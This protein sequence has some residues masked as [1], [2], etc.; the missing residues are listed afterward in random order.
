MNEIENKV[1]EYDVKR[2]ELYWKIQK[3][4]EE[5]PSEELTKIEEKYEEGIFPE[6]KLNMSEEKP[7]T[8]KVCRY[9]SHGFCKHGDSCNYFH[10]LVD[11]KQHIKEGYC[12]R[13]GCTDRHR[14][15]CKLDKSR[16]GCHKEACAYLH[17]GYKEVQYASNYVKELEVIISKL[18]LD[19]NAKDSELLAT[20]KVINK[21]KEDLESKEREIVEKDKIIDII[22][23]THKNDDTEDED[24]DDSLEKYVSNGGRRDTNSSFD[25]TQLDLYVTDV[26][27]EEKETKTKKKNLQCH[28]CE[29]KCKLKN[30]L[31]KHINTK[32][33][34]RRM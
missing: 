31:M 6:V 8:K 12:S 10:S 9:N 22:K 26:V 7:H 25:F 33:G 17:R 29:Y 34:A 27:L 18:K 21:L 19:V 11:C 13:T 23:N 1:K 32:H 14:Y 24:S 20:T 2:Q 16:K 28:Q 15:T 3:E 30:T 5:N 4:K